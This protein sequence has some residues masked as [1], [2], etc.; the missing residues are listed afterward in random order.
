MSLRWPGAISPHYYYSID[1]LIAAITPVHA[2]RYVIR[3]NRCIKTIKD[4]LFCA[5]TATSSPSVNLLVRSMCFS[6]GFA[7]KYGALLVHAMHFLPKKNGQ[8]SETVDF[9]HLFPSHSHHGHGQTH[10]QVHQATTKDV[11]HIRNGAIK[12]NKYCS[13]WLSCAT[14]FSVEFGFGRWTRKIRIEFV[15]KFH[16]LAIS[17]RR[18]RI[19]RKVVKKE[20]RFARHSFPTIYWF[21]YVSAIET[22]TFYKQMDSSKWEDG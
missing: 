11:N 20:M 14:M 13:E 21:V 19:K 9:F 4:N 15:P 5:G 17:I 22:K 10:T 8:A 1:R 6:C 2:H 12:R 7:L 18:I 16:E 3:V